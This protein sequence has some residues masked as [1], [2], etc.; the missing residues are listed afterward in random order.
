MMNHYLRALYRRFLCY[1]YRNILSCS[2]S[3]FILFFSFYLFS[4]SSFNFFLS[5]NILSLV[6]PYSTDN[7]PVIVSF[8]TFNV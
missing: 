5:S 6:S 8:F 2:I 7:L 4:F 1:F 3:F